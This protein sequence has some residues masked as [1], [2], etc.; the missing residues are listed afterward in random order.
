MSNVSFFTFSCEKDVTSIE[1]DKFMLLRDSISKYGRSSRHKV[2][3]PRRIFGEEHPVF[4]E[5]MLRAH[6]HRQ[7]VKV[8]AICA[9][10]HWREHRNARE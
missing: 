8:A 10:A 9:V 2:V 7:H 6:A 4:P 1:D 5:K 3:D